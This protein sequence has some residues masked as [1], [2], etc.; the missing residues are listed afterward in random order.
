MSKSSAAISDSDAVFSK[1]DTQ[2]MRR[3]LTLAKQAV[4]IGEVPVG[5]V[6][7]NDS[8]DIIAEAYNSVITDN[9]VGAHAEMTALRLA[10]Q[11]TNNYRL[12]QLKMATTLEPCPMCAGAIFQARLQ[13]VIFAA[14]DPKSGAFGGAINLAINSQ[15]NHHT[16][17]CGGLFAAR[18]TA[19]LRDFFVARR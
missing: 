14:A 13:T 5:A 16:R 2:A 4:A 19:L 15:L 10:G 7:Y 6:I 1:A 18:S 12:P 9:N 3:A 11:Q 17:V 8:G